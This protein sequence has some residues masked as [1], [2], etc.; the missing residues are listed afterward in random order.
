MVSIP[1]LTLIVVVVVLKFEAFAY[2]D[3]L[4]DLLAS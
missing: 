4:E 2:S 3:E 1:R